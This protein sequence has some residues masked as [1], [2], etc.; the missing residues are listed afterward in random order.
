MSRREW[1]VIIDARHDII[2]ITYW[3][4]AKLMGPTNWNKIQQ[5]K[6]GLNVT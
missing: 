4:K 2:Y 3:Q 5:K 6:A 1:G